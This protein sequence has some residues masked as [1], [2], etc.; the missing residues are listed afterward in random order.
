MYLFRGAEYWGRDGGRGDAGADGVDGGGNADG[1]VGGV[2]DTGGCY[3]GRYRGVDIGDIGGVGD[4]DGCSLLTTV[5]GGRRNA[6]IG[7]A[8]V[9]CVFYVI[10]GVV[11]WF[12]RR[13]VVRFDRFRF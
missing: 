2:G 12:R 3:R 11:S 1:V 10:D 4:D 13:G 5:V 6:R 8:A 9:L 7:T